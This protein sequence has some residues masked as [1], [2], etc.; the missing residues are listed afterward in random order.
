[1]GNRWSAT[2]QPP[3]AQYEVVLP[4]GCRAWEQ[5]FGGDVDNWDAVA[6]RYGMD[7]FAYNCGISSC[8]R[9]A[10][11][12]RYFK[13]SLQADRRAI[14]IERFKRSSA[15][16]P[17]NSSE[18][19]KTLLSEGFQLNEVIGAERGRLV[20]LVL[21]KSL[22]YMSQVAF[23]VISLEYAA[24]KEGKIKATEKHRLPWRR[25]SKKEVGEG[26]KGENKKK[27]SSSS[28]DDRG[29][30][31]WRLNESE[32]RAGSKNKVW[33]RCQGVLHAP[34]R[35]MTIIS[36]HLSPDLSQTTIM[37]Y[38]L[39]Q[40][41]GTFCYTLHCYSNLSLLEE[42]SSDAHAWALT[43]AASLT[44]K[45]TS[46]SPVQ[47]MPHL[48]Q[49]VKLSRE[50]QPY[51]VYD[52]RY[53]ASRIAVANYECRE[54]G[55]AHELV[56]LS[57]EGADDAD[58]AV[59]VVRRG[60]LSLPTLFGNSRFNLLYSKDRELIILQKLTD[61]R[62]GVTSFCDIYIFNSDDLTLIKYMTSSLPGL[63]HICK[64]SYEPVFSRCGSF[65]RILDHAVDNNSSG[66][67][68]ERTTVK[69]YQLPRTLNLMSQC[70]RVI[71]Q[72]VSTCCCLDF[73]PL[74]HKLQDY[75][76]FSPIY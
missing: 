63:F 32:D 12:L 70:R 52:P 33:A 44:K 34:H 27:S 15:Q 25:S 9:E 22:D 5:L 7:K 37:F 57:L 29:V 64:V 59:H 4:T 2:P 11:C 51:F 58:R 48:L 43:S 72:Q 75:L 50:V 39:C 13:A 38:S 65:M 54:T 17:V 66:G 30:P 61:D 6:A 69:V 19:L 3:K 40:T 8:D 41:T 42:T 20:L 74:P 26:N 76:R 53:R 10:V 67:E 45:S 56:V 24:E 23:P 60:K 73:L 47:R 21:K 28:E 46:A 62:F 36:C 31:E 16:V 71:L 14:T 55:I 18:G 1:M 35:D 49:T 68:V